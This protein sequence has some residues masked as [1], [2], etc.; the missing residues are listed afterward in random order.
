MFNNRFIRSIYSIIVIISISIVILLISERIKFKTSIR[1]QK[2][3]S[4]YAREAAVIITYSTDDPTHAGAG[5]EGNDASIKYIDGSVVHIHGVPSVPR[6]PVGN[7]PYIKWAELSPGHHNITFYVKVR[8]VKWVSAGQTEYRTS[9]RE[10]ESEIDVVANHVYQVSTR[11]FK[12]TTPARDES[13]IVTIRDVTKKLGFKYNSTTGFA[14]HPTDSQ[15][16][17]N[18]KDNYNPGDTLLVY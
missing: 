9:I 1:D 14:N 10:Y 5:K 15:L 18:V 17:F 3:V 4:K 7:I 2:V 11:V 8:N 12:P 6:N 13:V 16:S